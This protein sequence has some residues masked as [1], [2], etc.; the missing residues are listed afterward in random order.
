MCMC[1]KMWM[2]LFYLFDMKSKLVCGCYDAGGWLDRTTDAATFHQTLDAINLAININISEKCF[3]KC[4]KLKYNQSSEIW[5]K[6]II[7]WNIDCMFYSCI[8]LICIYEGN[9]KIV[10][11]NKLETEKAE[12]RLSEGFYQQHSTQQPL[13]PLQQHWVRCVKQSQQQTFILSFLW[14]FFS[15]CKMLSSCLVFVE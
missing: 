12:D 15:S 11:C 10:A 9:S 7:C 2:W 5:Y 13:I 6:Q 3:R 14:R 8:F 4:L 1:M